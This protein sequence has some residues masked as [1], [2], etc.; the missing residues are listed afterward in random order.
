[1]HI[2]RIDEMNGKPAV[3]YR[4]ENQDNHPENPEDVI[5]YEMYELGNTDIPDYLVKNYGDKMSPEAFRTISNA[6]EPGNLE[7]LSK[8]ERKNVVRTI[9]LEM[10]RIWEIKINKVLWLASREAV[11][12][13]YWNGESR[14]KP[15]R[16]SEYIL[17][18]L[19]YD[20]TLFAYVNKH[21][22]L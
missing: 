11:E 15:C 16:R 18:D 6:A 9:I 19:G 4:C 2:K 7:N 20:G 17:S 5:Y 1:M 8:E 13:L 14:I 22:E 21:S 12:E 3:M 10:E